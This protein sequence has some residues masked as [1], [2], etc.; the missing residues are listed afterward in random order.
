MLFLDFPSG[1]VIKNLSTNT[2]DSTDVGLI[3]GLGR[4][5]G[6]G[7]NNPLQ[8]SGLENSSEREAWWARIHAVTKSQTWLSTQN[9]IFVHYFLLEISFF[10]ILSLLVC[11]SLKLK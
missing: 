9:M 7:N 1:T 6:A 2:V 3:P 10:L 11:V 5:P 8:H 4:S